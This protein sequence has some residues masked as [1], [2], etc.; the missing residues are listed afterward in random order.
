VGASGANGNAATRVE[1]YVVS[2]GVYLWSYPDLDELS[3]SRRGSET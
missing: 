2:W 1:N 3:S